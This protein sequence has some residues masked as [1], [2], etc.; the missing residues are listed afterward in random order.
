MEERKGWARA[1]RSG[2][3]NWLQHSGLDDGVPRP[4]ERDALFNLEGQA[5]LKADD[6]LPLSAFERDIWL[7]ERTFMRVYQTK[8]FIERYGELTA[9]DKYAWIAAQRPDLLPLKVRLI[10]EEVSYVLD[11]CAQDRAAEAILAAWLAA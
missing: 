3:L 8:E 6:D 5:Y 7:L 2:W 11:H 9:G 1:A 4:T 10:L